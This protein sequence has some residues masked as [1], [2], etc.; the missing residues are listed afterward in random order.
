MVATKT[1]SKRVRAGFPAS[2]RSGD[3]TG[4]AVASGMVSKYNDVAVVW[5]PQKSPVVVAA[6]YESAVQSDEMRDADQDVLAAVGRIA[7][8]WIHDEMRNGS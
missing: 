4:T 8:D 6:Y 3:K 7:T 1:G 5:P 2:W